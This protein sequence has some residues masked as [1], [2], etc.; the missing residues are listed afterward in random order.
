M[1]PENGVTDRI[2][3]AALALASER[4]WRDVSLADIAARAELPLLEVYEA[5]PSKTAIL[6]R[7]I[8]STDAAVLSH[9]PAIGADSPRDRLFDV[10]MRRFDALQSRRTGTVA[11]LRD[12]PYDPASSLCLAARLGRSM[13]W[14]LEAAGISSSGCTGSV[15]VN[16]LALIYLDAIRVWMNDDSP[17]MARTMAAVDKGLR[18]AEQITRSV[19]MRSRRGAREPAG[20]EPP[21]QETPPA[22][23]G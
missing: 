10:I 8:G 16:G 17:D 6:P 7:L 18:R 1:A 21:V 20:S 14:M 11:I 15:K 5:F 2:V 13:A 4:G 23:A 22:P 9:G 3:Q 19:P 12:L